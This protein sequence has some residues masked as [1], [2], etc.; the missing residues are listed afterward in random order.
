MKN[1]LTGEVAISSQ[2]HN[3]ALSDLPA[4]LE[5]TYVNLNDGSCEGLRH[6][7][8]PAFSVQFH[9]EAAPGPRDARKLFD[10]FIQMMEK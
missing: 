10:Q 1:L 3:Y 5:L 9:P 8:L 2:N 4:E 7:T 6:K